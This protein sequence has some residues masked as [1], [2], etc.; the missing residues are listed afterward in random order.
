MTTDDS[1]E[2]AFSVQSSPAK[3]LDSEFKLKFTDVTNDDVQRADVHTVV[4]IDGTT[5]AAD[6][7]G[8]AH[9][10]TTTDFSNGPKISNVGAYIRDDNIV[11]PSKLN[12]EFK[13]L[14][15]AFSNYRSNRTNVEDTLST[16]EANREIKEIIANMNND[17]ENARRDFKQFN[18]TQN[19]QENIL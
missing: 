8:T 3:F 14:P 10:P 9:I 11:K 5:D 1:P 17:V 6:S 19:N 12:S 7:T 4:S 18:L 15:S 13:S 16:N 2:F